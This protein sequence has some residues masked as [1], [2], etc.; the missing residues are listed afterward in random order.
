MY[1]PTDLLSLVP[2]KKG[3]FKHFTLP[4]ITSD[5]IK[6]VLLDPPPTQRPPPDTPAQGSELRLLMSAAIIGGNIVGEFL[7]QGLVDGKFPER[8]SADIEGLNKISK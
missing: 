8:G 3:A 6:S 2:V 1:G 4:P 5:M 7:L